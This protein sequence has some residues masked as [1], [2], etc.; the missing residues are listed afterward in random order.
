MPPE[1]NLDAYKDM[2]VKTKNNV[3]LICSKSKEKAQ[4][5]ILFD[6][7]KLIPI[8][9]FPTI[10]CNE[11]SIV[12]LHNKKDIKATE[13][14]DGTT[15][16]LFYYNNRWNISTSRCIDAYSSYWNPR[17][18]FGEMFEECLKIKMEDFDINYSYC[19]VLLH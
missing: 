7:K 17:K 9:S 15:V 1:F 12:A 14:Y 5:S 16:L 4:A 19:F 11:Q 3:G 2:D 10:I 13:C 6:N 18:S 8:I